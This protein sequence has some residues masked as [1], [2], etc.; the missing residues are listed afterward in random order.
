MKC[1][2]VKKGINGKVIVKFPYNP[3]YVE[4]VKT[5]RGYCWHPEEKYWIFPNN[6][7]TLKRI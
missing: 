5:I 1:I 3:E 2:E 6:N 4:R 7:G